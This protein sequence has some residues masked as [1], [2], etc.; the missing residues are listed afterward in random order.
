MTRLTRS[1]YQAALQRTDLPPD[2]L[3]TRTTVPSSSHPRSRVHEIMRK[4]KLQEIM[5]YRNQTLLLF[6]SLGESFPP[7]SFRGANNQT[8]GDLDI[9]P[10]K[11][12][13]CRLRDKGIGAGFLWTA[14]P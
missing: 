7:P 4:G 8:P 9:M 11:H 10:E 13:R 5:A 3:Q 12:L 2:M 14:S 1:T 6:M